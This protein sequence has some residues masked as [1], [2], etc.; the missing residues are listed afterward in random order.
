MPPALGFAA[1]VSTYRGTKFAVT[2]STAFMVTEQ[3]PVPEQAPL[4]PVKT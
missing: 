1:V 2:L 3:A 4:H